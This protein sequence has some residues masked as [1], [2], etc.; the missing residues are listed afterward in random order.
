MA[1]D[2]VPRNNC[3]TFRGVRALVRRLVRALVRR[4]LHFISPSNMFEACH[5]LIAVEPFLVDSLNDHALVSQRFWLYD[6]W[7]TD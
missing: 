2:G 6:R 1:V 4:R 5:A 7:R 3:A